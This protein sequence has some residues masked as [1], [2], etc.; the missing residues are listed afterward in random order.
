M[1]AGLGSLAVLKAQ[2]LADAL[3]AGTRYD[4]SLLSIGRGVALAFDGYCDRKLSRVEDEI[5]VCTA[6]RIQVYAERYPIESVSTVELK[7]DTTSGW[8]TQTGLIQ[9][10]NED[11]GLIYWGSLVAEAYCQLRFTYTGGYWFDETEE[12]SDSLPVGA[13]ALPYDIQHAWFLQCR[14][15]WSA[16][17]KTGKDIVTTGGA[18]QFVT[19]SLSEIKLLPQ[20]TDILRRYQRYQMV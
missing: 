18:S 19:G 15:T 3:R 20:V 16:V 5:L 12:S 4:A 13:T 1:N 8:V 10:L 2:L 14:A 11:S 6:D 17:D 7:T 9:N